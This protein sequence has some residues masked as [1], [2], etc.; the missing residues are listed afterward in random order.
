MNPPPQSDCDAR[1]AQ[2]DC[3]GGRG[4]QAKNSKKRRG[5]EGGPLKEGEPFID[6]CPN[7]VA[8]EWD[9]RWGWAVR[10]FDPQ[11]SGHGELWLVPRRDQ[12]HI[13]Y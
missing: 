12:H 9:A 11:I 6:P 3:Y 7:G 1:P 2:S 5:A 10:I 8:L 13:T 4:G